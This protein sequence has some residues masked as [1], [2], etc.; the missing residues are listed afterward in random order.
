MR[1]K[2][3]TIIVSPEVFEILRD[4]CGEKDDAT[5]T[6]TNR[7]ARRAASSERKRALKRP[8]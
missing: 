7:K 5:H 6:P 4:A 1:A 3:D 8:A 2:P